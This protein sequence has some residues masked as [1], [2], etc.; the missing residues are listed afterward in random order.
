VARPL[1][2]ILDE[3]REALADDA[4]VLS[5]EQALEDVETCLKI[6]TVAHALTTRT[7]TAVH[8]LDATVE[9]CGRT[10]KSWLLEEQLQSKPEAGRRM[11]LVRFL[12]YYPLVKAGYYAAE[13]SVEHVSAL[14]SA[15]LS[16]PEAWRN[17]VEGPLVEQARF[18]SP[19]DISNMVDDILTAMN[20]TKKSD[21]QRERRNGALGF[22][23]TKT[24]DGYWSPSGLLDPET[25]ELLR[26]AIAALN[27]KCGPED[28]R[29]P[30]RRDH[31]ALGQ[32]ARRSL[33]ASDQPS[34]AGSPVGVM[35]TIPA[36]VLEDRL[37]EQWLT[38]PS[39]MRI[40]AHTARRLACDAEILPAV[41]GSRSEV[42]DIGRSSRQWTSAQ[43]RAAWLEQGGHCAFPKCQR[44]CVE[45]HHIEWWL[46]GGATSLDNGAW[47]CAFH[48][49]LV[50]D[51]GWSLRRGPD[52]SFVW[53]STI[54]E[55]RR[56]HLSAA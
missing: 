40:S 36:D 31:D 16:L 6:E 35:V 17:A 54:G 48:H 3:L 19:A 46:R 22:R 52:R 8:D 25:G 7:L 50:H 45:L 10:T 43:R 38:L 39:G 14:I 1:P 12:R 9:L 2:E 26:G 5:S 44:R 53:T 30:Q 41:L 42:L 23:L 32:I 15:L 4:L 55:E 33:E 49:W 34:F 13:F 51:G 11:K 27:A 20:V 21:I 18:G 29:T 56:R 37:R 28:L 47:L 24:M